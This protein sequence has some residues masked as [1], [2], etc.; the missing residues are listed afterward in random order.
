MNFLQRIRAILVIFRLL[1]M[2]WAEALDQY[3][4]DLE[5]RI[6]QA[7]LSVES[8]LGRVEQWLQFFADPAGVFNPIPF[9]NAAILSVTQL[10]AV[11]ASLPSVALGAGTLQQQQTAAQSS[12]YGSVVSIMQQRASGPTADDLE[13][14]GAYVQ[15]FN[16][17][18]Y[19]WVK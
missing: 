4:A 15:G 13:G 14:Y 17:L 2:K 6:N 12:T 1:H 7:F 18:G 9:L 3:I 19:S 16:N 11:L 8:D 5:N 10:Y